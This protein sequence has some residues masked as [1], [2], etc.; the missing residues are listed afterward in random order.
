MTGQNPKSLIEVARENGNQEEAEPL[1]LGVRVRELRK[2]G[3]ERPR[4][5]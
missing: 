1:D 5:S 2:A 3:L 4:S